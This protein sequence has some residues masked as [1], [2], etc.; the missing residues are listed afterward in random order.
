M[1][2]SGK[3]VTHV[4]FPVFPASAFQLAS[5]VSFFLTIMRMFRLL[6]AVFCHYCNKRRFCSGF[7][8]LIFKGKFRKYRKFGSGIHLALKGGCRP[9]YEASNSKPCWPFAR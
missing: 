3:S 6:R 5:V 1:N 4:G 7:I 2:G 8:A 9:Q